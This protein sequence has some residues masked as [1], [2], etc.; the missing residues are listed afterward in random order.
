MLTWRHGFKQEHGC[1][2]TV[3][4]WKPGCTRNVFDVTVAPGCL[5]SSVK[6][7]AR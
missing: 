5:L 3:T 2:S 6:W 7:A 4:E 1:S